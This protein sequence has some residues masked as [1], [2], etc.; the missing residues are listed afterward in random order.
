MLQPTPEARREWTAANL[1]YG[2]IEIGSGAVAPLAGMV[3]GGVIGFLLPLK[4]MS[5]GCAPLVP[6]T[7]VGGAAVGTVAG[8]MLA[9]IVIVEGLFDTFTGGA[10]SDRL[11]SWF[12]IRVPI[13]EQ[14]DGVMGTASS[15]EDERGA[16]SKN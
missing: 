12:N 14:L 3:A 7:T 13:A 5:E 10:F 4:G 9:P 15:P 2:P 6:Y 16:A 11:Y 8:A 1:A